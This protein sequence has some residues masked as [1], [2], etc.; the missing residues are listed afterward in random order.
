MGQGRANPAEL[1]LE[2]RNRQALAA[3]TTA[4]RENFGS[5]AGCHAGKKAV[6]TEAALVVG[7]IRAFRL[8]HETVRGKSPSTK[9]APRKS[10]ARKQPLAAPSVKDDSLQS[11]PVWPILGKEAEIGF[12]SCGPKFRALDPT[13]ARNGGLR[14]PIA[15][16]GAPSIGH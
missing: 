2:D 9:R 11:K 3:L 10:G 15:A 7:L 13:S 6:R 1:L 5:A 4:V 12:V 8:G 14:P 16:L